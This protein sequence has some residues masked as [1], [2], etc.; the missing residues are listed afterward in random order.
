MFAISGYVCIIGSRFHYTIDVIVGYLMTRYVFQVYHY[1]IRLPLVMA[2]IPFLS[3]YEQESPKNP[4]D[5]LEGPKGLDDSN[6][7]K[8]TERDI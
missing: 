5:P 2:K 7:S 6:D 8:G 4:F 3:W 1:I